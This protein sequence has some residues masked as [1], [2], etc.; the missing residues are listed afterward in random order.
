M[1][2]Y[3]LAIDLGTTAIKFNLYNSKLKEVCNYS[4]K[5]NLDK[6]SNF[7]EFD[8]EEYWSSCKKG[9]KELILKSEINPKKITSI[10]LSSQAETLVVLDKDGKPL[11]KAISWLDSRSAKECKILKDNFNIDDGYKITGQPDIV[12]NKLIQ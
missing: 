5:Y 2:K 10:S 3:I 12:K 7:I 1:K 8:A 4:I 11:R 9:I 6:S